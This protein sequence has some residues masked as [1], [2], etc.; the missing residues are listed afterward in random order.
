MFARDRWMVAVTL[1]GIA[2]AS[3]TLALS[4]GFSYQGV[5]RLD[6]VPVNE[7]AD[8]RFQ[9][10]SAGAGGTALGTDTF[11]SHPVV[12]GLFT[13]PDVSFGSV[14]EFD[15]QDLWL[16]ISVRVP[17][18]GGTYA[19]LTPRQPIRPTPYALQT[20]GLFVND[21][22]D[23]GVGTT[24]PLDRLHISGNLRLTDHPVLRMFK[25][26][27]T[28]ETVELFGQ[29][30]YN[31]GELRIYAGIGTLATFMGCDDSQ[32]GVIQAR[33]NFGDTRVQINGEDNNHAGQIAVLSEDGASS[34]LLQGDEGDGGAW[35]RLESADGSDTVVLDGESSN[36]GGE[37]SLR[38]DSS[39]TTVMVLG[40]QSDDSGFVGIR[41]R[42]G[43]NDFHALA[44]DAV[45]SLATGADFVMRN[46]DGTVTVALDSQDGTSDTTP[47]FLQ[48]RERDGSLALQFAG[49]LLSVRDNAGTTT[50]S[51]NRVTG[52]KTA[53]VQTADFGPRAM[54]CLEGTEVW[55][56]DLGGGQ[57]EDGVAVV[58]LDPV[59]LQ[60]VTIDDDH[61]YRV[62]VTLT[63]D[64]AGVFVTKFAD[65]FLVTELNGGRSDSTFDFRI[66]AKRRGLEVSRLDP[67]V[68]LDTEGKPVVEELPR[69]PVDR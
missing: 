25:D 63:D 15:G 16:E 33:N 9:L 28:T 50:C 57:L 48:L 61:P 21:G 19:P 13:A 4:I 26:D 34:L 58:P 64:C 53:I 3:N 66:T 54:Y 45:D 20:R 56:E 65:H 27:G 46:N 49:N 47:A 14:E 6:G 12:G 2:G 18:G 43:S 8:I 32:G 5:L 10:F 39:E 29:N 17:A 38:N 7:P 60:T 52:Q 41:N 67:W 42:S 1:L 68:E 44:L 22:L 24:D 40:D 55:F 36:G 11:L 37:V 62:A 59:F 35:C 31:G 23:V 30:A 69:E 51:W